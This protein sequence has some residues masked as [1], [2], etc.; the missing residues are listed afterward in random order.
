MDGRKT[1]KQTEERWLAGSILKMLTFMDVQ[2]ETEKETPL[3]KRKTDRQTERHKNIQTER[4][5][6]KQIHRLTDRQKSRET[7]SKNDGW[8]VGWFNFMDG[9]F[10]RCLLLL[11]VGSSERLFLLMVNSIDGWFLWMVTSMDGFFYE[12][13]SIYKKSSS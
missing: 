3:R 12:C 1:D 9:C 7:E 8:L 6:G 2:T 5:R 13:P 4:K 11:I 10:Y